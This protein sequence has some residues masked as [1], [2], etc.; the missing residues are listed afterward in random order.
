MKTLSIAILLAFSIPAPAHPTDNLVHL[1]E[2]YELANIILALTEYGKTDP[3]EV[4]QN[5]GYYRE[6]RTYFEPYANHPLLTKVNYSR[7]QWENYLSFRTDAY[8]FTFNRNNKLQRTTAFAANEGFNP[9][10]ENLTLVNDFVHKTQF[11]KFYKDHLPYYRKIATTYIQSQHYPQMLAFLKQELGEPHKA[12]GYAIVISPLVGRM[13]CHRQVNGIP[14]DFITLPAFLLNDKPTRTVTAEEIASGTHMLFTELDH[15]F[16]NPVTEQYRRQVIKKFQPTRWDNGSGYETDSLATFNE[17]MTWGIF[18]IFIQT[19]FPEVD[20]ALCIDWAL[21]NETRGFFASSL[22]NHELTTLYNNRAP[23]QTIKDL[24]PALLNRLATLQHRLTIPTIV[25]CNINDKITT[26]SI[27]HVIVTFSEPM[28]E[29]DIIDIVRVVDQN[30]KRT[31]EKIEI[32]TRHNNLTW[33]DNGTTAR[34]NLPLI[35][36]GTNTIIFNYAWKARKS[37]TSQYGINLPPYTR[38]K[39][40]VASTAKQ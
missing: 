23:G 37:I 16:V 8:A 12:S 31:S 3:W 17:Y 20:P 2:T 39:T 14:T 38:V 36:S 18:N 11:R 29:S 13:N 4:E 9:F 35:D 27:A 21:Q 19:C 22:F 7:K 26:D 5:S 10:E 30:G 25:A 28:R 1:S 32:S 33:Q 34:F 6:I 40:T 15:G 24:Y